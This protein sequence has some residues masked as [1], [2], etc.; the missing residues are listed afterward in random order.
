MLEGRTTTSACTEMNRRKR[1][2]SPIVM[3]GGLRKRRVEA[4]V[5]K[6]KPE[7]EGTRADRWR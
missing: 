3:C 5:H 7:N 6:G 2:T 1:K 4:S